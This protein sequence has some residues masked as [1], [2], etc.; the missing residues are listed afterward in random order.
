MLFC[1]QCLYSKYI[2]T[3]WP[4]LTPIPCEIG[5]KKSKK[6][7]GETHETVSLPPNLQEPKLTAFGLN[8]LVVAEAETAHIT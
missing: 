7:N 6:P 3:S 2:D 8:T 1:M 4:A 5:R